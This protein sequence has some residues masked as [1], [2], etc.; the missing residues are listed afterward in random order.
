[1]KQKFV[2]AV[3]AFI[4]S[5]LLFRLIDT[6][7]FQG[8]VFAD[9]ADRNR[10][11]TV[12]EPE[13]RGVFLDRYDQPLVFNKPVY[14]KLDSSES[15]YSEKTR[16]D[17]DEALEIMTYNPDLIRMDYERE[18][19]Y[20]QAL[21]HILGYVGRVTADDLLADSSLRISDKIG[22]MG[23]ELQLQ[24]Y[25]QGMSGFK[26]F[27]INAMGVKQHL[28]AEEPG[29][30]GN[31]VSTTLDPFLSQA[32]L[33]AMGDKLGSVVIL[34]GETGEVLALVSTPTFDVS[35]LSETT[36]SQNTELE[37]VKTVQSFFSHPQKLF[38]NRSISGAYPPGSV[39]KLITALSGL[40]NQKITK[41]TTVLDEGVLK[42]GEYSYANWYFTQFGRKEGDISLQRAIS[43]SND[44]YFY[45]VAEWVGPEKIKEM[46]ELFGLG[47]KTGL[48][49][50]SEIEGLLPDP[51]WKQQVLGERWF[52]GNTY[53]F[54][55]GQGDLLVSPIQVAQM[56]QAITNKGTLC[57]PSVLSSN[58]QTGYSQTGRCGE[59]GVMQ[60]N[61]ELIIKGMLDACSSGGTG[62]PFFPYNSQVRNTQLSAYEEIDAGA[63][64]C[65]TGT[66]EFGASDARGYRK[67]HGWFVASF[68][69]TQLIEKVKAKESY[70]TASSGVVTDSDTAT[71]SAELFEDK[72]NK[73]LWTKNIIQHGFPKKL[74]IVALV[75]SDEV[76]PY[77]EGSKDAGP[78]VK[79]IFDWM[80][81]DVVSSLSEE[82]EV[83]PDYSRE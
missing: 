10:T 47:K 24:D 56:I 79:E 53:H 19:R 81:A 54:G 15:L 52:L 65:K 30:S 46:A 77:R 32:A 35:Y 67:T 6:Q 55:I 83:I 42:V 31:S 16:I 49:I 4:F 27:E 2:Y 50:G 64:A 60:E 69:T 25:L 17:R 26:K 76:N 40:E 1:M 41:D 12:F 62:F 78:V 5:G 37:R 82:I 38:F 72:T 70:L 22:K 29:K 11:Y 45:K 80:F 8:K 57:T 3:V 74:V 73:E 48:Q 36:S 75:E 33:A 39:F 61:L 9:L 71:Q 34:D 68:G 21:A 58:F 66:S 14:F 23:L 13:Q 51:E 59:V 44:I 28:I 63:V 7:I 43:R 20:P 18:Y